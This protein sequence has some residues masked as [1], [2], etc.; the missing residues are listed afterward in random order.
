MIAGTAAIVGGMLI[1]H[2]FGDSDEEK[3]LKEMGRDYGDSNHRYIYPYM[4]G[5]GTRTR[6]TRNGEMPPLIR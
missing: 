6:E 5:P 1:N 3:F 4:G 2:F